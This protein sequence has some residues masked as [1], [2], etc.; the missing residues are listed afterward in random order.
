M[1]QTQKGVRG[2]SFGER[3]SKEER[4]SSSVE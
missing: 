4:E 1:K 2:K 3:V